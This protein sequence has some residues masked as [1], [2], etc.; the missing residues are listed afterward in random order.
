MQITITST[1]TEEQALILAKEKWYNTEVTVYTVDEN[2]MPVSGE[3]VPNTQSPGEF[4]KKVYESMII[5]DS[6]KHY[7]AYDL[8]LT[9]EA[10]L[11]QEQH[12]RSSVIASISSSVE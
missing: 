11:A 10:R 2:G 6:T 1:L 9:E 5:E 3:S 7:I 12:I 4:L 8:R